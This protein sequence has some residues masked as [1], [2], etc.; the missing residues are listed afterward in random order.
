MVVE[1]ELDDVLVLGVV[2]V[3]E[4]VVVEVVVEVVGVVGVVVVD[5]VV[6]VVVSSCPYHQ[7][8]PGQEFTKFC[9]DVRKM[10]PK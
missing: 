4:V 6:E 3:V 10:R 9:R 1:L 8:S 7:L 5:V 2:G